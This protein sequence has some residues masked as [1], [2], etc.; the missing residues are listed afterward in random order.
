MIDIEV[1]ESVLRSFAGWRLALLE[2]EGVLPRR[3]GTELEAELE[4]VEA[5]LRARFGSLSRRQIA[6][7]EPARFYAEH[8]ARAGKA[9]PVLLQ[10]ESVAS[11]GRRLAQSDPLVSAMFAAELEGLLLTAGHDFDA[12][13]PPLSLDL[14]SGTE[15]MPSFGGAQKAPPAG[16]LI[17]RDSGGIIASVLLGPDSRTPIGAATSRLL[18]VLYLPTPVSETLVRGQLDRLSALVALA[19]PGARPVERAVIDFS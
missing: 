15:L 3:G 5:G 13:R 6:L 9:Y 8:F 7:T 12:L 1:P 4:S 17:L 19:C 18:F 16:D 11:K 2:V 14:A 10:A